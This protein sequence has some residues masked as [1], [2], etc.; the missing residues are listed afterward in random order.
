[1]DLV[2]QLL[3]GVGAFA[4]TVV[5]TSFIGIMVAV[6]DDMIEERQQSKE[7]DKRGG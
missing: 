6:L 1:M 3:L 2:T 7:R 4:L 5:V